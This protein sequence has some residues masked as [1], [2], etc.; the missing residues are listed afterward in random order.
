MVSDSL[1]EASHEATPIK[2]TLAPPHL[3]PSLQS[4]WLDVRFRLHDRT[5][6]QQKEPDLEDKQCYAMHTCTRLQAINYTSRLQLMRYTAGLQD[7]L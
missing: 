7:I 2:Y 5:T 4:P 3:D 1:M 6:H